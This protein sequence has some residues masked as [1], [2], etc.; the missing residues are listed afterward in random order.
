VL[1][2]GVYLFREDISLR[3]YVMQ[4]VIQNGDVF[5]YAPW[6]G[7]CTVRLVNG[8]IWMAYDLN[9]TNGTR[10]W[11]TT[12]GDGQRFLYG[13]EINILW[14]NHARLPA[15]LVD[16]NTIAVWHSGVRYDFTRRD[17]LLLDGDLFYYAPWGGNCTLKWV[18]G[19][20]WMARDVNATD[21]T[22]VWKTTNG[23]GQRLLQRSEVNLL[24]DNSARL[25]ARLMD[26]NTIAVLHGRDRYDFKRVVVRSRRTAVENILPTIPA[27]STPTPAISQP[28]VLPTV[29]HTTDFH[30]GTTHQ[31]AFSQHIKQLQTI[32]QCEE[33][34]RALR[35]LLQQVES[36]KQSIQRSQLDSALCIICQDNTKTVVLLP[37]KHLCLCRS[38]NVLTLETCPLCRVP[39]R[40]RMNIIS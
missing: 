1:S 8:E 26:D 25:R 19:E 27:P 35:G 32:A 38:C 20:I 15:R 34:E 4:Q 22:R 14:D 13:E 33:E 30:S 10:V 37:C 23:D 31:Q 12:N 5:Y 18:N 36:R 7:N 9:A 2:G 16:Q 28:T 29:T 24:W 39:I 11:K 17:D 3:S 21:G 40:D 6:D